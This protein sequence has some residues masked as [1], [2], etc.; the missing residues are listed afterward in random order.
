MSIETNEYNVSKEKLKISEKHERK[1]SCVVSDLMSE[2]DNYGNR[3][4]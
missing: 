2:Y 1:N 3:I 4:D